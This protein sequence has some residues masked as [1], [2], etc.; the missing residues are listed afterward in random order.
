MRGIGMRGAVLLLALSALVLSGCATRVRLEAQRLPAMDTIGIRRIAVMPFE[1]GVST[2]DRR[3][4]ADMATTTASARL[5]E[6]GA[7][8]MVSAA[9]VNARRQEVDAVFSGRVTHFSGRIIPM[10]ENRVDRAT[11]VTTVHTFFV[12][13]VELA[14]EYQFVRS[15]D[16]TIIGP[17][18]R[19]GRRTSRS[20]S[21]AA[22]VPEMT[23]ARNIVDDQ[24]RFLNRDVAPYSVRISR[25]L[26]SER[27]RDLRPQ[28]NAARDLVRDGNLIAARQSYMGIW[29]AHGSIAA[30]INASIMTEAL[31]ETQAAIT[32]MQQVLSATGSPQAGARIAALSRELSQQMGVEAFDNTGT[33]L[34][35][36]SAHA[37]SEVEKV[38]PADAR[39]WIHNNAATNR[40]IANDVI[41][42]MVSSFLAGGV[43]VVERE[44]IDK[45][46]SE[47]NLHLDGSIS[48]SD[49][50]SIGNMTGANTIIVIGMTGTGANRRLQV[51]VLD[52][53]TSR[54]IMQSGT[55]S[56]WNL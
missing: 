52:I 38:L 53:A 25:T 49:F 28:M 23:L 18:S 36:V 34:E 42:N 12:R 20:D 17:V 29:Q 54:V 24:M 30:A 6:T 44:F 5:R 14:F 26:E 13:E 7:F 48:D 56:E 10:Q 40:D 45:I 35:T 51:R 32:F 27:N 47:Q 4:V 3:T 1:P 8:T 15:R 31:G 50:I 37:I 43:P 46:V 39:I 21:R 55:G 11:G 9:E 2:A 22:L 41:D 33:P 19:S 16:G